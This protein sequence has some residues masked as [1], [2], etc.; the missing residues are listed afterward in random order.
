V[1]AAVVP[2]GVAE[3]EAE[4]EEVVVTAAGRALEAV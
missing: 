4:A 3:E 1:A 2:V